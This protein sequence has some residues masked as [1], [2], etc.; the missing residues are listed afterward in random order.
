MA[1]QCF[2]VFPQGPIIPAIHPPVV[3]TWD[4]LLG[5]TNILADHMGVLL[6]MLLHFE[7]CCPSMIAG[8]ILV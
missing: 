5:Y 7:Q 8:H 4:I 3:A 2:C 6:E 1:R